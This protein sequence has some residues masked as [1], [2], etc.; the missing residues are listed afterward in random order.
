MKQQLSA[1]GADF[2]LKTSV[3]LE[4]DTYSATEASCLSEG[5]SAS[6]SS[7]L[8]LQFQ[9]LSQLFYLFY[10][11]LVKFRSRFCADAFACAV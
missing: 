2:A 8:I 4:N 10:L 5:S 3:K 6:P 11:N 7:C 9:S 1:F